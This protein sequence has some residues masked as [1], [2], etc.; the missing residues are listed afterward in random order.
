MSEKIGSG[1]G[2]SDGIALPEAGASPPAGGTGEP[3]E[4]TAFCDGGDDA[5]ERGRIGRGVFGVGPGVKVRRGGSSGGSVW[6]GPLGA[7]GRLGPDSWAATWFAAGCA[8]EYVNRE[9]SR[10]EHKQPAT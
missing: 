4:G 8:S 10:A 7:P 2:R 1:A 6:L 3:V 5:G 9:A